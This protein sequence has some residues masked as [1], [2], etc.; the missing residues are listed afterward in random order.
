MY[1]SLEN[2]KGYPRLRNLC[3]PCFLYDQVLIHTQ[4]LLPRYG[5]ND[6]SLLNFFSS[7]HI[8]LVLYF[9][10]YWS[11]FLGLS[12]GSQGTDIND[13]C[14]SHIRCHCAHLSAAKPFLSPRVFHAH[15]YLTPPTLPLTHLPPQQEP[16]SHYS[17]RTAKSVQKSSQ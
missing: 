16:T 11:D 15:L 14:L 7:Q 9:S 1:H 10:D 17:K 4:I 2:G 3:Y 8:G 6:L 13:T 5:L 12:K